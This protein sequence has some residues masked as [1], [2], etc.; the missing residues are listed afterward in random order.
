MCLIARVCLLAALAAA[1][2]GG[3]EPKNTFVSC[4]TE[5]AA[6]PYQPGMEKAG[7]TIKVRLVESDPAPPVKGDNTFVVDVMN[8]AG[9]PLEGSTV[10][11]RLF[12]PQHG[13][14]STKQAVVTAL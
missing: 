14:A 2:C 7:A 6:D 10:S 5:K 12:M 1:A 8:G 11:L 4:A 3:E 13:H 9:Q